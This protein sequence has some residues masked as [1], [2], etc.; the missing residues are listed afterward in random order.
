MFRHRAFVHHAK[1][2]WK[3][4]KTRLTT[5]ATASVLL[6]KTAVCDYQPVPVAIPVSIPAEVIKVQTVAAEVKQQAKSLWERLLEQAKTTT[7]S[8]KDSVRYLQRLLT[9]FFF[10]IP[11]MGLVPANYLLGESFPQVENATWTYLVRGFC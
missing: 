2:L 10:G 11:L 8:I 5:V 7:N 9:Y 4:E 1:R 3:Y 6:V